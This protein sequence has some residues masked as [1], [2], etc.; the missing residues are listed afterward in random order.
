MPLIYDSRYRALD[1]NSD[2]LVGATLTIYDANTLTLASV[3]RDAALSDAM[4]NPTSGA[5]VSDSGGWFPQIFVAEGATFDITLK[6]SAGATVKT[7]VDVPALGSGSSAVTRDFGASRLWIGNRS[8]VVRFEGGDPAGDNVG[9]QVEIGG[10]NDT[11]ADVITLDAVVVNVEGELTEN[12]YPISGVVTNSGSFSAVASVTIEL[13]DSPAGARA[14]D[15]ELFD[16]N[17]GGTGGA[18]TLQFS[19]D[20][21]ATIET[22]PNYQTKKIQLGSGPA[23][24]NTYAGGTSVTLYS[25]WPGAPTVQ[26][27]IRLHIVTTAT[28]G[29]T[30]LSGVGISSTD[31]ATF[32]GGYYSGTAPA[33]A[34]HVKI[35]VA[36]G[37]MSGR[38]RIEAKRGYGE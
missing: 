11:Q 23:I 35:A 25:G 4:T 3:Y 33:A 1:S 8:G 12:S 29:P 18:I 9:G 16:I 20:N 30:V 2:P 32:A 14:W 13:I 31:Y 15:L 34:T 10:W 27:F 38:Y 36:A 19:F 37:T 5:D 6:D 26:G 7:Y 24:T 28:T 17:A 21:G 22:S